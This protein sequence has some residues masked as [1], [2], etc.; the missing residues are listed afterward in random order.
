MIDDDEDDD[1][2][3]HDDLDDEICFGHLRGNIVG[4]QYYSGTVSS[5]FTLQIF[6]A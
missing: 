5:Y 1:L 2:M 3:G 4:I 6:V